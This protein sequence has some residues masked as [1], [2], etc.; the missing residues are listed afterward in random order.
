[1]AFVL[2]TSISGFFDPM[3][4]VVLLARSA[5]VTKLGIDTAYSPL[6]DARRLVS[7]PKH[8]AKF[9]AIAAL[10]LQGQDRPRDKEISAGISE[11]LGNLLIW[12]PSGADYIRRNKFT[13]EDLKDP[14]NSL[15]LMAAMA[16]DAYSALQGELEAP[17]EF[18][19]ENWVVSLL[20]LRGLETELF[21]ELKHPEARAL[22][23]AQ[24]GRPVVVA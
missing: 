3:H 2:P 13:P 8:R 9:T 24:L 10:L 14:E 16:R 15:G 6:E 21:P 20:G 5:V 23:E 12:S 22:L 11:L 17:Q 7:D 1:M 19:R 4:L 18:P